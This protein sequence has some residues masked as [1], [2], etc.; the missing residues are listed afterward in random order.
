MLDPHCCPSFDLSHAFVNKNI[1][2]GGLCLLTLRAVTM[3]E[4]PEPLARRFC[5]AKSSQCA[6]NGRGSIWTSRGGRGCG[7]A[8]LRY[9]YRSRVGGAGGYPR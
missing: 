7:W 2:V 9:R 8:W 5:Q 3:W 4:G 6:Q 1:S